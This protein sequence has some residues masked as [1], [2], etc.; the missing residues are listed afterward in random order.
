VDVISPAISEATDPADFAIARVLFQEYASALNVDLCFQNFA[1]ELSHLED[2]YGF[3][4]RGC[5]LL[6][7]QGGEA[8]GCVA[9]R[10]LDGTRCE[11]KRLYIKAKLRGF[12]FGRRLAQGALERAREL[13]YA[14]MVLDT[15]PAMTEAQS[16]YASL[17][18]RETESYY[19]NPLS[20][21]RYLELALGAA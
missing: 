8:I 13:G 19:P 14:R 6:L 16:L 9:I 15:L 7:R 1:E 11:M 5:L 21:A 10:N 18:F 17:G 4:R 12:G 3:P 2:M 20:G